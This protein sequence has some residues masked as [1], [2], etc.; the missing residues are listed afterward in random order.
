M[1]YNWY[2][3]ARLCRV[4]RRLRSL[5]EFAALQDVADRRL[6]LQQLDVLHRIAGDDEKIGDIAR[7]HLAER[8][9]HPHQRRA[10]RRR[11]GQRLGGAEPELLLEQLEFPGVA[12]MRIVRKAVIPAGQHADAALAHRGNDFEL[13]FVDLLQAD[14]RLRLALDR[15]LR[16]LVKILQ[17]G[18]DDAD[19]G[20]DEEFALMLFHQ[21]ERRLVGEIAVEDR[22]KAIADR[23]A[24]R[25]RAVSM[26]DEVDAI[27]LR[28]PR[29]AVDLAC[30]IGHLVEMPGDDGF[31][32]G[33]DEL[34]RI[35]AEADHLAAEFLDL[36]DTLAVALAAAIDRA[37]EGGGFEARPRHEALG[38]FVAQLHLDLRPRRA[39]GKSRGIAMIEDGLGI[40]RG[41][42]DMVFDRRHEGRHDAI[43]GAGESQMRV[44]LDETRHQGA[45]LAVD[46]LGTRRGDPLAALRHGLDALALDQH[47]ARKRRRA[48]AVEDRH[49]ADAYGSHRSFPYRLSISLAVPIDGRRS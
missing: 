32:A 7:L 38:D 30:G 11:R 10:A 2:I 40:V 5:V 14:L 4:P 25:F 6:V 47:L 18:L 12:A 13:A 46:D 34:H 41:D 31:R 1:Y 42:E 48:A 24:N 15:M 26:A 19:R 28:E 33:Q 39:A 37:L 9:A 16:H 20:H 23:E 22:A 8:V 29:G 17:P 3:L 36:G 44:G 35:D 45:A 43:D 27:L 21:V 49:V